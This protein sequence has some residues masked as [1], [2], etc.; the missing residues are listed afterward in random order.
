MKI[1]ITG[2]DG[3]IGRNLA[4]QLKKEN[5]SYDIVSLDLTSPQPVDVTNLDQLMDALKDVDVIYHLA[6][7]HRDD[8][9]PI[10]KYYDVNVGGAQNIVAAAKAHNIKRIIFTSTVA[11]YGLNAGE[12]R[13]TDTPAPFND[14]GQSKLDSEKIFE[15]WAGDESDNTLITLRLVATF[16]AGNR[17]N[18]YTLIAQI[19]R[20]KFIMIGNG[21]NHKSIAY[22][23]NVAGFLTYC[24]TYETSGTHIFNYAD[25]PD[26]N[27]HD[28]ITQIRISLGM[29]ARGIGLP[30]IAGKIGGHSFD[31]LARITGKNFPISAIRVEKFCAD[32]IVNADKIQT[33]G[34]T[35]RHSL[36]EGLDIMI[37]A[38]FPQRAN[39][40]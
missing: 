9:R 21:K 1:A 28:L 32:T 13:E 33:T 23:E 40:A 35:P 14:Y 12:S 30:Y 19:A 17:G 2:G 10:Q 20:K 39:A 27:M 22:V 5:P 31:V 16:G 7:E 24:L 36:N 8:V 11:V 37:K 18:I 38:E 4:V 15:E 34:Y 26:L 29:S 6:A 25:K 3:F